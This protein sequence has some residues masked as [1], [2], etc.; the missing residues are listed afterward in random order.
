[1]NEGLFHGAKTKHLRSPQCDLGIA[2]SIFGEMDP[3]VENFTKSKKSGD[4]SRLAKVT[5]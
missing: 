1:M 5:I 3:F 2:S 4:E